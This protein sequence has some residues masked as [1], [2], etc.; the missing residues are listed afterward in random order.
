MINC[1]GKLIFDKKCKVYCLYHKTDCFQKKKKICNS[2]N[3]NNKDKRLVKKCLKWGR[4]NIN[5]INNLADEYCDQEHNELKLK[6]G[7]RTVFCSCIKSDVPKC[8]NKTCMEYGY[9]H[10][11]IDTCK[12]KINEVDININDVT[13]SVKNNSIID[14]DGKDTKNIIKINNTDIIKLKSIKLLK[15]NYTRYLN[16][17]KLV[18]LFIFILL[19]LCIID[20][21]FSKSTLD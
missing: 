13:G 21:I 16:F 17:E 1:E 9:K 15:N 18:Y 8:N 20:I 3:I 2:M 19:F 10:K 4:Q 12:Q 5:S 11:E 14:F 6:S 7:F